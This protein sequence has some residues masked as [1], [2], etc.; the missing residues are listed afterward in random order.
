MESMTIMYKI[1]NG[2]EKAM[3]IEEF[4]PEMIG[5]EAL[6]VDKNVWEKCL[7]IL[8][9]EGYIDGVQ[10]KEYITGVS[11]VGL[12]SAAITMRGLEYLSENSMMKKI[13]NTM[14]GIKDAIPFA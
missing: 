12:D 3:G 10:I 1:L 2:L 6:G 11:V 9:K 5:F 14:K 8:V 13:G 7:K 4:D